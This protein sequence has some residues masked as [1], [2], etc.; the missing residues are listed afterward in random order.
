MFYLEGLSLEGFRNYQQQKVQF[1]PRLNI[2][3]GE[4]GQGKTN[5]LESIFYLSVTRSFRTHRDQE[6][7]H[8]GNTL[9][10]L[11]GTFVKEDF[12][13][14]VRVHYPPNGK[15]KVTINDAVVN[16]FEH[17]QRYPVIVFSPDDLMI[18]K[19]GPAV[20][21]RFINLEA[22]RLNNAY[23]QDL[24][25][26]QRVLM[27]RNNILKEKKSSSQINNL[28]APWD[29]A[30]IKYGVSLIKYRLEIIEALEK[31][32]QLFFDQMTSSKEILTIQYESTVS[33]N[34]NN[35]EMENNFFHDLTGKRDQELKRAS[36]IMGPHL[37]DIKI[38]INGHDSRYY[39]SQGQKRTAAL[40]LK[41]SELSLFK[42]Q[43]D[44]WPIILLDD[45]FS[46]FDETRKQHLLD[47]LREN[48]GQC[49]IT[50]AVDQSCLLKK[51]NRDYKVISVCQG[52]VRD[53]TSRTGA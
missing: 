50:T 53:E 51:V 47:F 49:F 12:N 18:I 15:L 17:M 31:E 5:L 48:N 23:L 9:F 4:N 6:L 8:W 27:Q 35:V 14:T 45:V 34:I 29:Q 41:M 24:K 28:L 19:E 32:A 40:A 1:H 21:R 20:R 44:F 52:N 11:K 46:E 16:R 43:N 25:N 13:N 38:Y 30:L 33:Y 36:T 42:K 26:Y 7:V 37:D 10:F 22:S 39:S 2:L 3:T